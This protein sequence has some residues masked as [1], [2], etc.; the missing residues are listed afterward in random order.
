MENPK[1]KALVCRVA[2]VIFF[3]EEEEEGG[4]EDDG[5]SLRA[6]HCKTQSWPKKGVGRG[7]EGLTV[8]LVRLGW[9]LRSLRS[10]HC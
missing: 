4:I 3:L 7:A 5:G 6:P 9:R 10:P 8:G 2:G 1:G